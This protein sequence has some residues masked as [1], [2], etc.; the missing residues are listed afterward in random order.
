LS[1]RDFS[2]DACD[3]LIGGDLAE[4]LGQHGRVAH[5]DTGDLDRPDL[6]RLLIDPEVDLASD[7]ALGTAMLAPSSGVCL[8]LLTHNLDHLTHA[9]V[10]GGE[11]R[12]TAPF[13]NA[14]RGLQL[15]AFP[16]FRAR[17]EASES[18]VRRMYVCLHSAGCL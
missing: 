4:Q 9:N 1:L 17:S 8:E 15:A 2:G 16:R 18:S 3:L 10:M 11:R 14:R 6:Q 7:A 13:A 12:F 5:V